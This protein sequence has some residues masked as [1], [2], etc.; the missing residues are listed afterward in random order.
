MQSL[1]QDLR[2]GARMLLKQPGFT[3]I[4][5]FTLAL[6]I[7]ATTAIFTIVNAALLRQ[8]PYPQAE[9]MFVVG[10]DFAGV[11][12]VG[13][14]DDPRFVFW[15]DHQQSFEA[16]VASL[17]MGAGVNLSGDG[18]PEF[19]PALRV[20]VD[21]FRV[22]GVAPALG[23]GFTAEEDRN[24]GAKV[25]VLSDGLW[26]RRYGA[27]SRAL[28]KTISLNGRSYTVIGV[29]P[30]DFRFTSQVDV[31][32]PLSPGTSGNIGLNLQVLG[33]LKPGVTPPQA[34]S[35]M[36]LVGEQ[37]RA[38]QPRL[39]REQESVNVQPYRDF[40]TD[41]ARSQLWILFGAVSFVLLIACANVANL[42][43]TQA[44]LR[45]REI[46]VRLALG[47]GWRRVARQL[48]TEGV[49]L[50]FVGASLGLLLA[51]WGTALLIEWT[52]PNLIPRSE[53]IGIDGRVLLF[54]LLAAVLTGL[55]FALAPAWQA[56]RVD[57]NSALK[58][59]AGKGESGASGKRLRSALVVVEIALALILLAGATLLARTFV[60]LR[61]VAP[62]FDPN[63][64]L[65]FQM[66]LTGERYETVA[67]VDDFLRRS[68]EKL[69]GLPGVEAVAVTN[70]LPLD[71]QYNFPLELESKPGQIAAVQYRTITPDYLRAI[72]ID[73]KAGRTV[74]EG[75][76]ATAEKAVVVNEA[77]VKQYLP[78][79]NF[80]GAIGQRLYIGRM[81][82]FDQPWRIVGVVADAKQ[83]DLRS[84]AP[85]SV[86]V[87]LLQ[88]ANAEGKF[89]S[90]QR[91][92]KFVL[93]TAGEP[94][95]LS[96]AVR[97]AMLE[98][99]PNLSLTRMRS[100]EQILARSLAQQRFN[101]LL[102]GVFAALGLLLAVIGVYGVM[103]C[104]V[105]ERAPEIGLRMALGAQPGNVLRLIF[106]HGL[107]LTV[108]GL[109][110]GLAGALALTRLI[111]SYL[112]GVSATD[113]LTFALIALSLA[114]V[115]LVACW[116]PARRATKVDPMIALRNE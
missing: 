90:G 55:S 2:Y 13:A 40:L 93:R 31:Y 107:A 52:P 36:K 78:E 74:S 98:I 109:G 20:S 108:L 113:P 112:F 47:A 34:L 76:T 28:G 66:T 9:R 100:M 97:K 111:K 114:L 6:G 80:P 99:E 17:P 21:F 4:A 12:Q 14:V 23:R 46:A 15:R 68:F 16:L 38:A 91:A 87:P 1:W 85:S 84:A 103:S 54:T 50:A 106:K 3:L 83:F 110:L 105:A 104:S 22:L 82:G 51:V 7:G 11:N 89:Q 56:A 58:E 33:R 25:A 116:L 73:L 42:Q 45:R 30:P 67:G 44:A 60:N 115:A 63:N 39:M 24:G 101:M 19:V 43:L 57:M 26:Q 86:F 5:V 65:T 49:L 48:L 79:S 18:E 102:L 59:A 37:L 72:G 27:D 92:L 70:T 41:S 95:Q 94:L 61:G 96:E 69:R 75:D 8:L 32:T 10:R 88:L 62:G 81:F 29:M 77:F 35:E 64:A 53:E 71:A